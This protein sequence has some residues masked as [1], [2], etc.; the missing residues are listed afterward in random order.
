MENQ[1]KD[2]WRG[3][4]GFIWSLIG[5]AVGFGNLLSFSA[6]AYKNGGGA[7]LIPYLLAHVIIGLPLLFL[8]SLMGQKY[9]KPLVTIYGQEVK[10][11]GR[12]FGWF[13]VLTCLTIGGFYMVLTG[14]SVGYTALSL[15]GEL[16]Q[17]TGNFF[18]ETFLGVSSGLGD[19][20]GLSWPI[21]IST[22][23]VAIFTWLVVVR[24]VQSGIERLCVIFLPMLSALVLAAAVVVCF[25][26]GASIGFTHFLSPDY[27]KLWQGHLWRDAFGQAFF[28]LSLG[29]GI[30]TGYSRHNESTFSLKRAMVWVAVGDVAIS[31][32]AGWAIFGCMGFLSHD[33]GVPF[34]A[35]LT[36]ES[37]FE[38]GFVIF[39]VILSKFGPAVSQVVAPLFFFSIFIAGV[40]GVFS[41]VEAVVGN[42]QFE[43]H[44]SRPVA[45]SIAMG[46]VTLLAL[47]FCMGNGQYLLDA[48]VPMVLGNNMLIGGIA[49]I[50]VFL[51]VV[52]A[53][54]TDPFWTGFSG[55]APYLLLRYPVLLALVGTLGWVVTWELIAPFSCADMVRWGYFGGVVTIAVALALWPSKTACVARA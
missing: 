14:F 11:K 38:I 54:K 8:E 13:A 55:R 40:T 41:I 15:V 39:P 7:F 12:F 19:M 23:V 44:K 42:V 1:G 5:S 26:P 24:Q 17:D 29:L 50:C 46:A 10:R 6:Q 32:V 49:E 48:L 4:S 2:T 45:V 28:S 22:L 37:P 21:L 34:S 31:A 18:R 51:Y 52:R 3:E 16:P 27:S 20:G 43:F 53:F 25:L 47:P 33:L 9:Q 36:S 30:V 35:V